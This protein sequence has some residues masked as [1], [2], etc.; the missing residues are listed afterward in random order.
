MPAR[1]PAVFFIALG[2]V[3]IA[4]SVAE[5][6]VGRRAEAV[7][8]LVRPE[9]TDAGLRQHRED[10][11]SASRLMRGLGVEIIPGLLGTQRPLAAFLAEDYPELA[12][13]LAESD[14]IIPF[15][16]GALVNLERQQ[17]RFER[18]DAAP[19]A[20]LPGYAWA[21]VDGALGLALLLG[22]VLAL[23][24]RRASRA[25]VAIGFVA[26]CVLVVAPLTLGLP[27]RANDAETVLNSLDPSPA[28]VERTERSFALAE[29]AAT[30]LDEE[31]IPD[32][33]RALGVPRPALEGSIAV[34]FPGLARDL[35]DLPEVLERYER[36]VEIRS[37]GADDLRFLQRWPLG[38][39]G[40]FGPVTGVVVLAVA[41]WAWATARQQAAVPPASEQPTVA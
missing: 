11:E 38:L 36:R 31:F 4:A 29:A 3:V 41:G 12:A 39:L 20:G 32:V 26:G 17:G 15:A 13:F 18:A 19:A 14:T 23:G 22:G 30:E 10:F 1:L 24:A 25:G 5:Y 7:T 6:T 8:D 21:F 16:E 9:M 28:V 37:E 40:W 27:W 35:R 2:L 34:A 33:A